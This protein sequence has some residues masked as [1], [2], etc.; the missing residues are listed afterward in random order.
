MR[1]ASNNKTEI[2]THESGL[3]LAEG[4]VRLQQHEASIFKTRLENEV[5]FS[6]KLKASLAERDRKIAE[7]EQTLQEVADRVEENRAI[8]RR[9]RASCER[10][11]G[12]IAQT[13]A[14]Q[15]NAL[16]LR[17]SKIREIIDVID[18]VEGGIQKMYRSR[19][20]RFANIVLWINGLF[21]SRKKRPFQGYWR[22]DAKL[23]EYHVLRDRYL[24]RND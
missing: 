23:A 13:W 4:D 17:D 15:S 22:I 1:P 3:D 11:V 7:L 9:I 6:Q 18:E 14:Q 16:D 24:S 20:W 10:D 12:R 19:R 2:E 21:C 8:I 5:N